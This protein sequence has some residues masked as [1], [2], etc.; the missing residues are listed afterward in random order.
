MLPDTGERYLSTPLFADVSVDMTAEELEIAQSTPSFQLQ[1]AVRLR[2]SCR[3]PALRVRIAREVATRAKA[4][5]LYA[6]IF[7]GFENPLP[8]TESPGLAQFLSKP[9]LPLIA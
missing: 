1:P 8:R 4:R 5:K 2:V 6:A 3:K 9:V 7:R